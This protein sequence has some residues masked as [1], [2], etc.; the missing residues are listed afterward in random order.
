MPSGSA[1]LPA[2]RG[3][4]CSHWNSVDL[5]SDLP[6]SELLAGLHAGSLHSSCSTRSSFPGSQFPAPQANFGSLETKPF[7]CPY[8][9]LC[10]FLFLFL[11]LFPSGPPS[12]SSLHSSSQKIYD[13]TFHSCD[14]LPRSML[15]P[16]LCLCLCLCPFLCRLCLSTSCGHQEG[17]A[18][19]TQR[20]GETKRGSVSATCWSQRRHWSAL[21]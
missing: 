21:P 20:S 1:S 12:L 7:L 10:L 9:C 3:I 15:I 19:L 18:R 11:F 5:Q 8:L 17:R 2:Q 6:G 13:H 14:T 16:C 4:R